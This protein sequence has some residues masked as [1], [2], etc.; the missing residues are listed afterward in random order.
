[1]RSDNGQE[2]SP[3]ARPGFVM[4]AGLI[5][6]VAVFLIIVV[7]SS[8]GDNKTADQVGAGTT[9]HSTNSIPAPIASVR[10]KTCQDSP[11]VSDVIPTKAPETV[12]KYYET[13]AYPTSPVYGPLAEDDGVRRCFEHSPTG[14]LFAVGNFMTQPDPSAW[15]RYFLTNDS[16]RDALD[17]GEDITIIESDTAGMRIAVAGFRISGYDGDSTIVELV[18]VVRAQ[19]KVIYLTEVFPLAWEDGDWKLVLYDTSTLYDVVVIPDADG[20]SPWS[21]DAS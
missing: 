6:L 14:A 17:A 11:S 13:M 20:Y 4:S 21:P 3:Y 9:E 2:Q 8:H 7:V 18:H 19:G 16:L 15:I 5:V 12:W 1:M 10:G